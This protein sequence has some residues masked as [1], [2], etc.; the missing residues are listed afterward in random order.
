MTALAFTVPGQPIPKERPRV[1]RGRTYTPPRTAAHETKVRAYA[2]AAL[3]VAKR[4]GV[5][6]PRDAHYRVTVHFWRQSRQPADIDNL[7]KSLFDG[8]ND[9]CWVDDAR[10]VEVHATKGIDPDEPRTVVR[11]EVV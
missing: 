3:G 6:W 1:V 8:L 11:I 9:V 2:I 4:A 5:S 10:I 7:Q